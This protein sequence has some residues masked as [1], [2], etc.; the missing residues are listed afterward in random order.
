MEETQEIIKSQLLIDFLAIY[1]EFDPLYKTQ[2]QADRFMLIVEK[3]KCAYPQFKCYEQKCEEK[4]P[5]LMFI[6]HYI[7]MNGEA[8]IIGILPSS[9]IKSSSSV[10]DVSVDFQATPYDKDNFSYWLALSPYGREYLSW[11]QTQIGMTY[12]N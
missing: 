5:F 4:I 1:P 10:G 8:K 9:G 12:V 11:L 7:V 6:A 3:L 2:E